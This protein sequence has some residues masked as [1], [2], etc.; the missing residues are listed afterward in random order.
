M[1]IKLKEKNKLCKFLWSTVKKVTFSIT[2]KKR[3]KDSQS[4]KFLKYLNK[5]FKLLYQ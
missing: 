3:T 1:T 4:D 5:L 2:T